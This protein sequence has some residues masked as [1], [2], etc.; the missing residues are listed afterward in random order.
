MY[1]VGTTQGGATPVGVGAVVP[2]VEGAVAPPVAEGAVAACVACVVAWGGGRVVLALAEADA[3]V[4][5]LA[6]GATL[7]LGVGV[8]TGAVT[9][10]WALSSF[11]CRCASR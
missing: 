3:L 5:A 4:L 2:P 9:E 7:A 1:Q 8:A 11:S 10:G 6:D